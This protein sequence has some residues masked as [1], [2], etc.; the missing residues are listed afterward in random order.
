MNMDIESRMQ[1][2]IHTLRDSRKTI[3]ISVIAAALITVMIFLGD[4]PLIVPETIDSLITTSA[5]SRRGIVV[6]VY[7]GRRGHPVIFAATYQLELS[8]LAGDIGARG[9]HLSVDGVGEVS[10]SSGDYI[11]DFRKTVAFISREIT[12]LPGDIITLGSAG[13]DLIIPS[14]TDLSNE[15]KIMASI[16]GV[17]EFATSIIESP[18]RAGLKAGR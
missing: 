4:Q 18:S 7:D 5:R 13:N 1:Y 10:G 6:P 3:V 12:L 15:T 14:D 2:L 8:R 11:L 16:E 9:M 17:G